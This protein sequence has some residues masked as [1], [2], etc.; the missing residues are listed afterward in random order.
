MLYRNLLA[1]ALAARR[2]E[3]LR[4]DRSW[5]EQVADYCQRLRLL[6]TLSS[7]EVSARTSRARTLSGALPSTELDR[8]GSMVVPFGEKWATHEEARR[9]AVEMLQERV[10]FAAD[11]S[12]LTPG[13]EISLPLAVVQV[14]WFENPHSRERIY[15]KQARSEIV[16]PE[17]L[18][19]GTDERVK[20]DTVVDL[21]RFRL[22][23][24]ETARFLEKKRDWQER[25]ERTPVALLDGTLLISI[26]L[27]K[28]KIQ[29]AYVSSLVQL[30][31][32]SRETRVP[33]V[34]FIDQSYARDLV[35][36]LDVLKN[37]S[38]PSKD[39]SI[40]DAQFLHAEIA[41]EPPLL[42]HWGA[43]TSFCYSLREGFE[44]EKGEPL[45]G[46]T[47]LQ[48]TGDGLPAR[49]DVPAWV[50]EAGLLEDVLDTVRAECVVGL[51]YP[52]AIET[53][54]AAAVI[55]QRE[56]AEFLRVVQ[57]FAEREHLNFGLSRKSTS[58]VRRR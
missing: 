14:A 8:A 36:L 2:E 25:G 34:G 35:R 52:Y 19:A 46:F 24:E 53:A 12:Q 26:A 49:L 37:G 44:D 16:S 4:F 23:I 32:L 28:T 20:A 21:H 31:N 47:Y 57:E 3:F 18:L 11:G 1:E 58:K 22:E 50:Y 10:T 29:D 7:E 39:L 5:R 48:T 6:G 27:P 43:R 45:V 30:I 51:G 41:G 15:E 56:R 38:R 17:E 42:D 9:W 40:Y 54:D 55:S 13:K 33:L